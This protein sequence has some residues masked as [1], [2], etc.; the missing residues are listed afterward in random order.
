VLSAL[1]PLDRFGGYM[2]AAT[3]AGGLAIISGAVYAAALPRLSELVA[4]GVEANV[5]AFYHA[6]AQVL[7]ALLFPVGAVL[8]VFAEELM[9]VWTGNRPLAAEIAPQVRLLVGG[10]VLTGAYLIPIALQYA[11]G[12]TRL[13]LLLNTAA[14]GV[15]VPLLLILT[16]YAGGT[17]AAAVWLLIGLFT[18]VLGPPVMHRRLLRGESLRWYTSDLM[19]PAVPPVLICVA[20]A[21]VPLPTDRIR[22]G[23]TL[24]GVGLVALLGT[25][26][27]V[28]ATRRWGVGVVRRN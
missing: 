22:L 16:R 27:C 8:I 4:A 3:V 28:P 13:T 7:G 15:Q 12:W 25:V 21:L 18:V 5:R 24:A 20:L 14:I 26:V 6:A 1:L 9:W 19:V 10:F 23:L 2:L 17:G 11:H